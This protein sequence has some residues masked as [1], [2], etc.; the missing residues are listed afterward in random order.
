MR[1]RRENYEYIIHDAFQWLFSIISNA[2]RSTAL[3]LWFKILSLSLYHTL[4]IISVLITICYNRTLPVQ[5]KRIVYTYVFKTDEI[6]L[7]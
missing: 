1:N 5:L 3:L 7:E 6:N 4:H 2:Q